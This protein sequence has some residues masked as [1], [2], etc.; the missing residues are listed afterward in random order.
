MSETL[1]N[2]NCGLIVGIAKAH[3]IAPGCAM[4]CR[5]GGAEISPVSAADITDGPGAHKNRIEFH[6]IH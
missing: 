2:G 3:F 6:A 5:A 4:A 1:L